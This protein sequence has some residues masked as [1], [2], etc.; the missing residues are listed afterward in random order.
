MRLVG[1]TNVPTATSCWLW[2]EGRAGEVFRLS[3]VLSKF[4]RS[5]LVKKVGICLLY[6][7]ERGREGRVRVFSW[8]FWYRS[9]VVFCDFFASERLLNGLFVNWILLPTRTGSFLLP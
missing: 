6:L 8:M 4:L 3:V 2:G 7:G 1:G 5:E 9:R